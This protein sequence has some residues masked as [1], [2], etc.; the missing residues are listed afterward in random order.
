[1]VPCSARASAWNLVTDCH[2]KGEAEPGQ[3]AGQELEPTSDVGRHE[4]KA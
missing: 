3:I 1:M 4:S 2:S